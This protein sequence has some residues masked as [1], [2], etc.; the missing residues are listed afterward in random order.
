[1]DN[2]IIVMT[3]TSKGIGRYLAE[4]YVNRGHQVIGCS[5]TSS[6]LEHQNYHHFCQDVVDETAAKKLFAE[7]RRTYNR[8]DVLINNAGIASMN[9]AMTTPIRMLRRILETN[10]IG[11]YLFSREAVK[12]MKKRNY[13]RIVTSQ[14]S[15]C[16]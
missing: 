10:V 15:Q 16:P 7:V 4:Y 13:G 11:T 14:Q 9:L 5:R 2:E 3:G 6:D 8:L 1:M 12:Q